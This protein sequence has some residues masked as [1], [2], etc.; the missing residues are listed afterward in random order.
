[1]SHGCLDTVAVAKETLDFRAFRGRFDNN[2][3]HDVGAL[4]IA[5]GRGQFYSC[6]NDRKER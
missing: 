5:A 3:A 6:R 1:V 4:G 2:K